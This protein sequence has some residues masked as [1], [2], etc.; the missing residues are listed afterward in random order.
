MGRKD[1]NTKTT[2]HTRV[3]QCITTTLR[4][5]RGRNPHIKERTLGNAPK[6]L[7]IQYIRSYPP[8]LEAVSSIHNLRT[9]HAMVTRDPPNMI[10]KSIKLLTM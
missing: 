5:I 7:L 6:N 1:R 10:A 8:Y 2:H 3:G 9:H 4:K